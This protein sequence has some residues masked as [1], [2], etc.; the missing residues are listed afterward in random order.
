MLRLNRLD[1][2]APMNSL[3][4]TRDVLLVLFS[5]FCR[6]EVA[7]SLRIHRVALIKQHH[8]TF[9]LVTNE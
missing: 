5:T 9:L 8:F 3:Q 6:K 4:N 1:S 7:L 2:A